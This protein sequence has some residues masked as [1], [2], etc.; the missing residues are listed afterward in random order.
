MN[1]T[2]NA[3]EEFHG[4][5]IEIDIHGK[6]GLD[7]YK[8]LV[9]ETQGLVSEAQKVRIL[10]RMH[11][12]DGWDAGSLWATARWDAAVFDHIE[13]I[14]VVGEKTWEECATGFSKPFKTA[15][16]RYFTMEQLDAARAWL[17]DTD[18]PQSTGS[19]YGSEASGA[20][21]P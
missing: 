12:F 20:K 7:Q 6:E 14:A 8:Q 5:I 15:T 19:C 17:N 16:V 13:R 3:P 1:S 18:K 21:Q 2:A 4:K 9:P 10:A 11:D